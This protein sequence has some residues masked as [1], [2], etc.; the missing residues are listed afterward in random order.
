MFAWRSH[1]GYRLSVNL[2][3]VMMIDYREK[4]GRTGARHARNS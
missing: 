2:V 4:V 1:Q 3:V